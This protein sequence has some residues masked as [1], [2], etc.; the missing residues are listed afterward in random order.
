MSDWIDPRT[1]I[2]AI[3]AVIAG[4]GLYLGL[5]LIEEPDL[6]ALG[7]LLELVDIL[8]VVLTSVGVVLLIRVTSRQRDEHL[9]VIRDLE[10]ARAQGQRWRS[11]ARSLLNGL[12]E[13]IDSQFSR[14][15]LTEAEREVALLLLK[16]LSQKEIAVVRAVSERTVREQA[17]S[18]YAKAG[19]T[20]RAGLSAFFLEDLLAPIEGVE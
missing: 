1:R 2:W 20:G 6:T 9:K 8:P 17:R 16:G 15:N 13:A 3:V 11:E 7:L 12:G 5:E 4:I 18:I 10:L 14:W 19:L